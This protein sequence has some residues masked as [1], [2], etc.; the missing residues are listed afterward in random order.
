MSVE[1]RVFLVDEKPSALTILTNRSL[2]PQIA[3]EWM[4]RQLWFAVPGSVEIHAFQCSA[5]ATA[6][7]IPQLP[8]CFERRVNAIPGLNLGPQH[9]EPCAY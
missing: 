2:R 3:I 4:C 5:N 6:P 8:A 7:A 9:V 1:R